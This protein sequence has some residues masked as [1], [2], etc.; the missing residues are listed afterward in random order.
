[1]NRTRHRIAHDLRLPD[2][3]NECPPQAFRYII[4]AIRPLANTQKI[5]QPAAIIDNPAKSDSK[6]DKEYYSFQSHR[7]QKY[8]GLRKYYK[9]A[10]LKQV[11]AAALILLNPLSQNFPQLFL[12][13]KSSGYSTFRS[14]DRVLGSGVRFDR[15]F[16]SYTLPFREYRIGV[17]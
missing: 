7:V 17:Q 15:K 9:E 8:D 1:M 13:P 3:N 10:V 12:M 2:S 4:E 5:Q 11:D 16:R 14:E 6:N